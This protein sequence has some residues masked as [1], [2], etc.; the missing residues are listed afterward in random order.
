MKRAFVTGGSGFVGRNLIEEL[1][2]RDVEV[3]ALAWSEKSVSAVRNS[4]A[5]AVEGDLDA[6]EAMK[7]GMHGCDVV[8][9]AAAIVTLWGD[10][11]EFHRVNVQGTQNV[12]DAAK[13]AGVPRLVH[14]STEA[15]LAGGTPLI[16][17]DETWPYPKKPVGLYPQTKCLAE[18]KVVAAN[19]DG[20][21]TVAIRPPLIWGKGDTSVLPQIV[22]AVKGGQW[23]WFDGGHYPH[24]TTNIANVVEGL[25]LAAEKGRGGEV[26][27]ISDG[28]AAD[29]RDFVT[30]MLKTRGV[31]SESKKLPR[32]AA[33]VIAYA[34]EWIWK[35][36]KVKGAPP[37]PRSV[38]YVMG[39]ELTVDDSKARRELGYT[40]SVTIAEGLAAMAEGSDT[41]EAS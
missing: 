8:F 20:L 29:F 25:L 9:H 5:E 4:G 33:S 21:T 11:N 24:T 13:A 15:L 41:R 1:R 16:N 14:V 3:R 19:G 40:G 34:G 37:L 39:C 28:E 36:F 38:L 23:V 6:A 31:E 12:I 27:F 22:A 18:K 17:A 2:R 35:T 10:P 30:A 26:Y 32:W 7:E